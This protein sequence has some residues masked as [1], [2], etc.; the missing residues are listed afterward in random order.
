MLCY[1]TDWGG[2]AMVDV[3]SEQV[4]VSRV[5]G[6]GAAVAERAATEHG[7]P[8]GKTYRRACTVVGTEEGSASHETSCRENG[9]Q[10]RDDRYRRQRIARSLLPG[11]EVATCLWSVRDAWVTG[12]YSDEQ[13]RA[14]FK[15]LWVCGNVWVCPICSAKV[16]EGRRVEV[17]TAL[18]QA[19]LL[20]LRAVPMTRTIRHSREDKLSDLL[21][22]FLKARG[23]MRSGKFRTKLWQDFGIAGQITAL[24]VTHGE[25]SGWHVHDHSILLVRADADVAEMERRLKRE[26]AKVVVRA[27]LAEVNDHGLKLERRVK[28]DAAYLC[29][30]NKDAA[31]ELTKAVTKLGRGGNRTPLE[32]L[33]AA[34]DGSSRARGLWLEY[35]A[36]FSNR[37]QLTWSSG[38]RRL[39]GLVGD[40]T[41]HSLADKEVSQAR[42]VVRLLPDHWRAVQKVDARS[43]VLRAIEAGEEP[44]GEGALAAVGALLER[45]GCSLP[46]P[47]VEGSLGAPMVVPWRPER[48]GPE[49][50]EGEPITG[51][52]KPKCPVC[53]HYHEPGPC[54]KLWVWSGGGS[55]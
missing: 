11:H 19:R 4:S 37:N 29:K 16:A 7:A 25:G 21:A 27:G 38:L 55:K 51:S 30:V 12:K 17:A 13:R 22:A 52:V 5:G 8:L 53:A 35:A 1:S 6:V 39:L 43:A 9:C 33:D 44:G 10:K 32:L 18:E 14:F 42:A 45:I 36:A 40:A 47:P 54:P 48:W 49:P 28:P 50:E 3:T 15:G 24:E 31:A 41:D 34:G 2:Q 46:L 26:W 20:G 23:S